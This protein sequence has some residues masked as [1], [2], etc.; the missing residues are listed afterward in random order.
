M[1]AWKKAGVESVSVDLDKDG[2]VD[3]GKV[4]DELGRRGIIQ[5][6]VEG[7][8]AFSILLLQRNLM[9]IGGGEIQSEFLKHNLVDELGLFYGACVSP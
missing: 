3:L 4:L 7:N 1:E 2:R 9:V 8:F 5:L 6:L